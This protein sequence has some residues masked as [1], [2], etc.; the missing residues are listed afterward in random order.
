MVFREK[1]EKIDIFTK[2]IL[3][4]KEVIKIQNSIGL[5]DENRLA[6]DFI[7]G[8]LNIFYG[9]NLENLNK[10]KSNYPGIDLGDSSRCLG[11]QVTSD[12]KRKKII[13]TIHKIIKHEVYK[14]FSKLRLFI[15]GDKKNSYR[16]DSSDF[17]Q[18]IIFDWKKD[19]LDC[20]DLIQ[21]FIFLE[22]ERQNE[23]LRYL[24]QQGDFETRFQ[25]GSSIKVGVR[26]F[27]RSA[28]DLSNSVDIMLD[29]TDLFNQRF[30]KHEVSWNRELTDRIDTFIRENLNGE[31]RYELMMDTHLSICF[32]LGYRLNSK[33][34]V[35]V[36]VRQNTDKGSELWNYD[37][38]SD[39]DYDTGT[40]KKL[41]NGETGDS[42]LIINIGGAIE[43]DVRNYIKEQ[44][45]EIGTVYNFKLNGGNKKY[46][47]TDGNHAW[48]IAEYIKTVLEERGPNEKKRT[49]HMFCRG[50]AGF[51]FLLGKVAASFGKIRLYE[52]DLEYHDG[53]IPSI[54]LP[55]N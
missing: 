26:S 51:M 19:I 10:R 50:P 16:L 34:G 47:I 31:E 45:L 12:S 48:S 28:G 32:Y 46:S 42:A 17:D 27:C 37:C 21:E 35:N 24:N 30:L 18:Y 52:Y 36:E 41:K 38:D 13:D 49:L 23:V 53:Y 15:I 39:C 54:N 1:R 22:P 55:W 44:K 11:I 20:N 3:Y 5:M 4:L 9:Y 43:N 25:R 8:L 2:K 14:E 6:E 29:L 40:I 7:A 33:S